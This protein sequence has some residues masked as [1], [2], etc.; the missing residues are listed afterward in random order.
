MGDADGEHVISGGDAVL[1]PA[2]TDRW[3]GAGDTGSPMS[4]ISFLRTDSQTTVEG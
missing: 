1:I 3:H 2:D 4:H